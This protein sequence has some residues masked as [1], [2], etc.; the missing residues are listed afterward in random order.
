MTTLFRNLLCTEKIEFFFFVSRLKS[1]DVDYSSNLNF[2]NFKSDFYDK[3]IAFS[4]ARVAAAAACAGFVTKCIQ[5]YETTVVRHGL[6]LVGPTCSGKT[7]CYN[8]LGNALT[9]LKGKPSISGGEY[10]AVHVS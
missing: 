8:I 1:R 10:E 4:R 7:K 5:L 6:M 2:G 3:F 9:S